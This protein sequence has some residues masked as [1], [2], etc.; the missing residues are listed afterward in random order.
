MSFFF[1]FFFFFFFLCK[2]NQKQQK[3]NQ[4]TKKEAEDFF[5]KHGGKEI[6][7]QDGEGMQLDENLVAAQDAT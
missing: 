2:Y 3:Q 7:K 1:F 4:G 6:G 5:P